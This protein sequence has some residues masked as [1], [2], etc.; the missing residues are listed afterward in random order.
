MQA[1]QSSPKKKSAQ[2]SAKTTPTKV[3]TPPS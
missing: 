1:P 2:I 3:M